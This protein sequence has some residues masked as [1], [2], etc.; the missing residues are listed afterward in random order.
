MLPKNSD[1]VVLLS[2]PFMWAILLITDFY[3]LDKSLR[4]QH[5]GRK[6]QYNQSS[7]CTDAKSGIQ[8]T[9]CVH[10]TT[11]ILYKWLKHL[12]IPV[13]TDVSRINLWWIPRGVCVFR[14]LSWQHTPRVDSFFFQL[15]DNCFTILCWFLPYIKWISHRYTYIPEKAMAPHYSILAWRIPRTEEPGRLQSMGSQRVGHDWSNLA[16]AAATYIYPLLP[17][18]DS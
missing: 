14:W 12:W 18:G 10:G 8:R 3:L 5:L 15:N 16:A 2:L 17:R 6:V 7:L 4:R 13:S 9:D 11:S 1:P